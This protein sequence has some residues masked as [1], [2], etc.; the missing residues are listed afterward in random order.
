MKDEVLAFLKEAQGYGSGEEISQKLG[1]TRAAIWKAIKK[2][3]A[4][5]YEIESSTKKGYKLIKVP[6]IITPNEVGEHLNTDY[7]G[8]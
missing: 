5:G 2:L 6:N 7:F 8:K 1:V 4:E 3:Q